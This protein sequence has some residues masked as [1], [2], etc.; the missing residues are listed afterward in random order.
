MTPWWR[1]WLDLL[2][3]RVCAACARGIDRNQV[4]CAFCAAGVRRAGAVPA[5]PGLDACFAA[6][7]F[8][9]TTE[10]WIRRFKY[11]RPGLAG[12][13]PGACAV[14]H[15]LASLAA[16]APPGRPELVV[17]VPLHPRR[18]HTR[19]FNPAC[20][21]AR[22]VARRTGARLAPTALRRLRDTPSQTGLGRSARARNV[23]GAF[24]ARRA[25]PDH[26][27]LVDDVVTTGAT[28]SEA[29]RAL[30]SAGARHIVGV[31]AARTPLG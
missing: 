23:R 25:L 3:P 31:C 26:V 19:G 16:D 10:A 7:E 4:L 22:V 13:D 12:L 5:P 29:A 17:P 14:A 30:R 11:P 6:A 8:A 20:E 9:G 24:R 21:L 28:L 18:L 1:G 27:W 2:A 15:W